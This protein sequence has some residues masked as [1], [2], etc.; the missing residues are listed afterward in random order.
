MRRRVALLAVCCLAL[1]APAE[2]RAATGLVEGTVAPLAW[3]QEVE[4]CVVEDQPSETCVAPGAEGSYVLD[5]VPLEG[6]R[7]EF[8]PSFRSGLLKQ[9]YDGVGK[10]S[11][12]RS[13]LLTQES[14]TA[15]GIDAHLVEGGAITGI[16]TD[17]GGGERLPEVE[18]CAVSVGSPT[19]KSCD[20]TDAG[21]EYE[22]HSLPT[23]TYRVGFRGGGRSVEYEPWSHPPVGV[24]AGATTLG[25]DA[26]LAKGAR[27]RG[28]VTAAAGGGRLADIPV[29]LFTTTTATGPQRC[30]YSDEAGEYS[31]G[32]LSAGSYQVGFSLTSAEL[33]G[34]AGSGE[35]G[36]ETQY[37]NRVGTRAEAAT[38]TLLTG[39]STQ[40]VDAA[41]SLSPVA[42]PPA[43][44]ALV[45]PPIVVAPPTIAEP[46]PKKRK[47]GCVKPRHRKKVKGKARCVKAVK[48]KHRHHHRKER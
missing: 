3:A 36:Y 28:V 43:V 2:A 11:D 27:I 37:Y 46:K 32:G 17:A 44:A 16:V 20:E 7:I 24:T 30:A 23:G 12:A 5:E 45:A 41:L 25:I 19:V 13:V 26:A 14:P 35:D 10:L 34:L 38:L 31:F 6:A 1:L 47:K 18:V 29:C 48:K 40:G 22:L 21:G 8:I 42:A 39:E 33:G 4:V 9:Y 15:K